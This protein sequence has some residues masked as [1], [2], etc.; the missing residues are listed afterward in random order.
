MRGNTR[1]ACVRSAS[2]VGERACVRLRERWRAAPPVG[3]HVL[4]DGLHLRVLL[5]L[6]DL[7]AAPYIHIHIY[8]YIYTYIYIY[9]Y[10]IDPGFPSAAPGSLGCP[11]AALRRPPRRTHSHARKRPHAQ[12]TSCPR[13]PGPK[14]NAPPAAPAEPA[15]LTTVHQAPHCCTCAAPLPVQRGK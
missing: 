7:R 9:I 3:L 6:Q 2:R 12:G 11:R 10:I 14:S 1:L 8:I 13:C 4:D 5:Q 15:R